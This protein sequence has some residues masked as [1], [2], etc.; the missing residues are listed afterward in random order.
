MT[1]APENP[2]DRIRAAVAQ[3]PDNPATGTGWRATFLFPPVAAGESALSG[4]VSKD[5]HPM[6]RAF[7]GSPAV[8]FRGRSL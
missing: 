1:T 3:A 4:K 8:I 7:T 2:F 6:T 5:A